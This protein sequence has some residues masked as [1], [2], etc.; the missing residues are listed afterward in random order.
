MN[1][2]W[3]DNDAST[4]YQNELYRAAENERLAHE[5]AQPSRIVRIYA[6]AM[7]SL[8]SRMILWGTNLQKRNERSVLATAE[9]K[10]V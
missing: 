5:V 6:K 3:F 8:G 10:A 9:M 1:S 4:A 2:N 7:S